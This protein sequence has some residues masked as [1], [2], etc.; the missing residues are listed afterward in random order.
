MNYSFVIDILQFLLVLKEDKPMGTIS[1]EK[2]D[3]LENETAL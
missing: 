3:S 1:L 2:D